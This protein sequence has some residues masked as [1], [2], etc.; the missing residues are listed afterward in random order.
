M[1]APRLILR[2]AAD[3]LWP[4]R[5]LLSEARV[6]RPGG[7]ESD[8]W[9]ALDFLGGPVCVRCGMPLPEATSPESV[10]PVCI[11]DPPP[12]ER[13]R[14]ALA[15]DDLSRPMILAFKHG[16][17]RDGVGAF[18]T[19]LAGAA[20]FAAE[21]DWIAPTPLHWR[22]LVGRGF[23]QAGV[24]AGALARRVG[25]PFAPDLLIRK[26]A[27]PSQ[28]GLSA[29]GRARNVTGAFAVRPRWRAAIAGKR[30]LLIDDVYTTGATVRACAAALV[31]AGA[32]AVDVA[33][34]ARVVRPAE[35]PI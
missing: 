1:H 27:T 22:R 12:F 17:R 30:I 26:R 11:A 23:N 5:S 4:P 20:P 8:L 25:R 2:A 33:C 9:R 14:A 7:I 34:L 19:W 31:R 13:A 15:Y 18:A 28:A 21:A 3:L 29:R 32:A 6:D 10:C 16:G 35:L 24:L